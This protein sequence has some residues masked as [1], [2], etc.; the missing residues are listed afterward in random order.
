MSLPTRKGY[1]FWKEI[2]FQNYYIKENYKKGHK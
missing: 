1:V 2:V